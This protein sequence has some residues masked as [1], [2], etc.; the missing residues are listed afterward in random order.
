MDII[1][2]VNMFIVSAIKLKHIQ[3]INVKNERK[4]YD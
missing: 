1:Q 2:F 4:K 3:I